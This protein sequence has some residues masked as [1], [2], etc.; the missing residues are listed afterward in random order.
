M[1]V[2]GAACVCAVCVPKR[3]GAAHLFQIVEGLLHLTDRRRVPPPRLR[4]Q[5]RITLIIRPTPLDLLQP[6]RLPARVEEQ[7]HRVEG[8][9]EGLG[10]FRMVDLIGVHAQRDLAVRFAHGRLRLRSERQFEDFEFVL[11]GDDSL[12]RRGRSSSSSRRV[13]GGRGSSSRGIVCGATVGNI[14]RG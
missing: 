10:R 11:R 1:D 14:G 3:S 12:H 8:P 4:R 7:L 9:T 5:P 6:R 2:C 13:V